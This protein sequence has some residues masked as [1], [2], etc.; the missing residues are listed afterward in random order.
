MIPSSFPA[1]D[2]IARLTAGM[3]LEIDA[4]TFN[5]RDPFTH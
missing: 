5:S 3:L 2:E 1:K 4:I